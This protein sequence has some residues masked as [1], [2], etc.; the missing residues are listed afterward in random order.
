M[1]AAFG[2]ALRRLCVALA[3]MA[4][5]S[6]ASAEEIGRIGVDWVGNDIVVEA[7]PDPKVDG[8]VCHLTYF[9]RSLYDRVTQGNWFEDPS[10]SAIECV[11]TGPLTIG[12]IDRGRDGERVFRERQS[13]ILKAVRV[14]RIWDAD[15]EVLVYV[16]HASEL[17]QGSAKMA[18][19]TVPVM[20]GDTWR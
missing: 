2:P 8:V 15:N 16:A 14:T 12:N 20:P 4:L 10:N 13:L 17:S 11:R 7:I 1:R 19:S 3:G 18:I 5:A 6:S 9:D